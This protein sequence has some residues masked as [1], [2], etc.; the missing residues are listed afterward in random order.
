M[1]YKR[2]SPMPVVEGGTGDQTLTAHGVLVGESTSPITALAVGTNG[3]VLLGATGADP[4]FATLTSTGGTITF[5]LG[6]HSLNLEAATGGGMLMTT[7]TSSGTWTKNANT[8]SVTVIGFNGGS[9]GGSGRRATSTTSSG[10]GGGASAGGWYI[11]QVPASIFGATETVTVGSG[12]AGGVA[13]AV[14]NTNGNNGALGGQSAFGNFMPERTAASIGG[15]GGAAVGTGGTGGLYPLVALSP[16]SSEGAPQGGDGNNI[17]GSNAASGGG[18]PT[19]LPFGF[20]TATAGGGG[21][22]AD[23]VV[24]CSGGTGGTI[25]KCDTTTSIIAGGTAGI[26]SGTING[27]AGNN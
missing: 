17:E 27:G 5:T 7:F 21:G 6:A 19:S 10:G 20:I 24:I 18:D 26:E 3:Q 23:S 14:N 11:W 1:A 4:A 8:V 15:A 22:G 16:I 12:G 9:G 2:Q 25:F 13:Q